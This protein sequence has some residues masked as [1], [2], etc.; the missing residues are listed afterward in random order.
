MGDILMVAGFLL[1]AYS[2]VAN[3]AIQTLGTFISSNHHRPWW[4]LWAFAST[5]LVIVLLYGWFSHGG[6]PAYGRLAKFP[7]PEQGITWLYVI[8]PLAILILTRY[9]IPVSTT[10]LVLSVFAAG[11]VQSMLSKSGLGYAVAFIVALFTYRFVI[12]H[13]TEYFDRTYGK[14]VPSYWVA[15]QWASTGFLWSQWLIQDLANI[16]AYLPRELD[17]LQFFLSLVVLLVLHAWIFKTAGGTIQRIVT[18]KTGTVDIRAAT[19]ID[20]IYAIILFVF[21]EMSSI[22]MSTTWVFLGLL[23]GREF[24]I[25]MHMFTPSTRETARVVMSDAMKAMLGLAISL[26]LAFGLP[27]LFTLLGG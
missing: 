3:D 9:G 14:P 10:F 12:R 2:I 5:I 26:L 21:K 15:L 8:P 4:L 6:D 17:G 16:Y 23:A 7:M 24:A 13:L 27:V 20:F 22:P 19:I 25:S 18:T 1:A 11:N